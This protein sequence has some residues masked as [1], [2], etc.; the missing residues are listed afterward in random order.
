MRCIIKFLLAITKGYMLRLVQAM[1]RIN[2]PES[3]TLKQAPCQ[4][5]LFAYKSIYTEINSGIL[6]RGL[7]PSL[8]PGNREVG[9]LCTTAT[10]SL[11]ALSCAQSSFGLFSGPCSWTCKHYQFFM[12][13]KRWNKIHPKFIHPESIPLQSEIPLSLGKCMKIRP[14]GSYSANHLILCNFTIRKFDAIRGS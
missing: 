4:D 3:R 12:L 5:L 2:P 7:D 6:I 13:K 14:H 8:E 1:A 10:D 11:V 9:G